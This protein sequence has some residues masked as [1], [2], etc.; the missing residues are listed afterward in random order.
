MDHST[1][2]AAYL[3]SLSGTR[4]APPPLLRP[5]GRFVRSARTREAV[6]EAY[7]RLIRSGRH[8]AK[9]AE[10]AELA[11]CSIRTVFFHFKTMLDLATATIEHVE[12][13][14]LQV[15]AV[16]ADRALKVRIAAL[17]DA[18]LASGELWAPL[19][20]LRVADVESIPALDAALERRHRRLEG[21]ACLLL[22]PELDSLDRKHRRQFLEA[23]A[24]FSSIESWQLL[25]RTVSRPRMAELLG[26]LVLHQLGRPS[27][28]AL[29]A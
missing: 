25:S 21:E 1:N 6:I 3:A 15:P 7:L 9:I 16:A 26:D 4:N 29:A 18:C 28:P 22:A 10:I 20:G 27:P 5:D 19:A 12:A 13:T 23:F 8:Q 2:A 14:P 24:W 17:V 11:G